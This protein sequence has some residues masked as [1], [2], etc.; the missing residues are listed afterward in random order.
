[1][2]VRLRSVRRLS[3][4]Q[5]RLALDLVDLDRGDWGLGDCVGQVTVVDGQHRHTAQGRGP[6]GPAMDLY[7]LCRTEPPEGTEA[8]LL[9][10]MGR[11]V[12]GYLDRLFEAGVFCPFEAGAPE[13]AEQKAD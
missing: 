6:L 12:C 10:D 2:L 3:T 5:F 7:Q 4:E 11:A 8:R 1:M 9:W 13:D